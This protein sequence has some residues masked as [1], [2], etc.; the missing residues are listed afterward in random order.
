MLE[1]NE[2]Y[3]IAKLLKLSVVIFKCIQIVFKCII[4]KQKLI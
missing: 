3:R 4:E 2:K 1:I